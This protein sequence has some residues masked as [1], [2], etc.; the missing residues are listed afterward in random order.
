MAGAGTVLA[1]SRRPLRGTVTFATLDPGHT[2]IDT[3]ALR[4]WGGVAMD[5]A[6][7]DR[8][9][10]PRVAAMAIDN[11]LL[12]ESSPCQMWQ[13][14]VLEINT[15]L[16]GSNPGNALGLVL[17][18]A[19]VVSA[20]G[21]A[22]ISARTEDPNLFQLTATEGIKASWQD[23][24][25]AL[26]GSEA[27]PARAAFWAVFA[28]E[29]LRTLGPALTRP[30]PSQWRPPSGLSPAQRCGRDGGGDDDG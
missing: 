27:G 16:T 8:G 1:F 21:G 20:S 24:T 26:D 6:I 2:P 7:G 30:V 13:S 11:K 5:H 23:E 12:A 15:L 29:W 22:A 10:L 18:R 9:L 19:H 3:V 28:D 4:F 14:A 17:H 25:V